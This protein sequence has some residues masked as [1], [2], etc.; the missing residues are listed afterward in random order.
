[1]LA[2]DGGWREAWAIDPD[3]D[4]LSSHGSSTFIRPIAGGSF[5]EYQLNSDGRFY[6]VN[7][8]TLSHSW[9]K[10]PAA[11]VDDL[12]SIE[13]ANLAFAMQAAASTVV[14]NA[15]KTPSVS[16]AVAQSQFQSPQKNASL[17]VGTPLK[18]SINETTTT[19]TTTTTT[20]VP[21][22]AVKSNKKST[23]TEAALPAAELESVPTKSDELDVF[24]EQKN[25][26]LTKNARNSFLGSVDAE[27]EYA[28]EGLDVFF[29][30]NGPW[31]IPTIRRALKYRERE[32]FG[33]GRGTLCG[34]RDVELAPLGPGVALYFRLLLFLAI[35]FAIL[36][37][38]ALPLLFIAGNGVR[39]TG[40]NADPFYVALLSIG[41]VGQLRYVDAVL[42][43]VDAAAEQSE[44]AAAVSCVKMW[45][46]AQNSLDS[47]A[48]ALLCPSNE[49]SINTVTALASRW[50]NYNAQVWPVPLNYVLWTSTFTINSSLGL[51]V[52]Y[53]WITAI[54]AGADVFACIV[55]LIGVIVFKHFAEKFVN[56]VENKKISASNYSVFVSGLPPGVSVAEIR[57]HFSH[58]FALDGTGYSA[59]NTFTVPSYVKFDHGDKS[60]NDDDDDDGGK[61]KKGGRGSGEEKGRKSKGGVASNEIASSSAVIAGGSVPSK[62]NPNLSYRNGAYYLIPSHT[63]V[64]VPRD[65]RLLG[66]LA[67]AARKSVLRRDKLGFITDVD[68]DVDFLHRVEVFNAGTVPAPLPNSKDL[69]PK[70]IFA[71]SWVA[72][73]EL[74][75]PMAALI[76]KYQAAQAFH[77]ELRT[78]RARVKMFSPGTPHPDGPDASARDLACRD[79]DKLSAKLAVNRKELE[80]ARVRMSRGASAASDC[81]GSAFVTFEHEESYQRCLRAY[82]TSISSLSWMQPPHLRFRS[83]DTP[84]FHSRGGAKSSSDSSNIPYS[85]ILN[86]H[87]LHLD[88]KSILKLGRI[89]NDAPGESGIAWSAYSDD[90]WTARGRGFALSVTAAPDPSD[91]IHENLEISRSS[92]AARSASTLLIT[93]AISALGFIFMFTASWITTVLAT[94][95][96]QLN[97]CDIQVPELYFGGASNLSLSQSRIA[98]LSTGIYGASTISPSGVLDTF[99]G[100]RRR[101]LLLNHKDDQQRRA[102]DVNAVYARIKPALTRLSSPALRSMEDSNCG[103]GAFV[104]IAYRFDFSRLPNESSGLSIGWSEPAVLGNHSNARLFGDAVA[105]GLPENACKP[106]SVAV[107]AASSGF[108]VVGTTS[109]AKLPATLPSFCPDPRVLSATNNTGVGGLCSC[110]DSTVTPH[111]FVGDTCPSLACFGEPYTSAA[112]TPCISFPA[113]TLI[114]CYCMSSLRAYQAAQGDVNGAVA[115]SNAEKDACS[116]FIFTLSVQTIVVV[117]V[118]CATT[119]VNVLLTIAVPWLTQFEGHRS[120]SGLERAAAW[121][122]ALAI[123]I[124]T[125]FVALLVNAKPPKGAEVWL[126]D[127]LS[128][129]GLLNG[130][131]DDFLPSWYAAVGTTIMTTM[132]ANTL[133]TPMFM[134]YEYIFDACARSAVKG[135]VGGV[136]TQMEMDELYVGA[137]FNVTTRYPVVLTMAFVTLFYST[138]IP[139]LF[140]LASLGFV[141]QYMVDKLMLLKFYRRPPAYDATMARLAIGALPIAVAVKFAFGFWMTTAPF[142]LPAPSLTPAALR[143]LGSV[144]S[145][146]EQPGSALASAL[147]VTQTFLAPYDT[148]GILPRALT[149]HGLVYVISALVIVLA[150]FANSIFTTIMRILWTIVYSITCGCA[151]YRRCSAHSKTTPVEIALAL[152][153]WRAH[154]PLGARLAAARVNASEGPTDGWLLGAHI[155]NLALPTLRQLAKRLSVVSR[156][157][158]SEA[159]FFRSLK[160]EP[161]AVAMAGLGKSRLDGESTCLGKGLAPFSREF[162]RIH[163]AGAEKVLSTLEV[164]LGWRLQEL[165]SATLEDLGSE[166]AALGFAAMRA[167]GG[168]GMHTAIKKQHQSYRGAAVLGLNPRRAEAQARLDAEAR[169]D[170]EEAELAEYNLSLAR[171]DAE[172]EAAAGRLL[173]EVAED[174]EQDAEEERLRVRNTKPSRRSFSATVAP[175]PL[176]P[177]GG[178]GGNNKQVESGDFIIGMDAV[179]ALSASSAAVGGN[180]SSSGNGKGDD[181]D[182]KA[183]ADFD[184]RRAQSLRQNAAFSEDAP[185]GA[186]ITTTAAVIAPIAAAVGEFPQ[187]QPRPARVLALPSTP[188]AR[189]SPR[190]HDLLILRQ[191]WLAPTDKRDVQAAMR[192][193]RARKTWEVIADS[194]LPTYEIQ[195]NPLYAAAFRAAAEAQDEAA[196]ILQ[197][198]DSKTN[199]DSSD[200]EEEEDD[201]SE[202]DEKK[203][204]LKK[205]K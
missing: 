16:V 104:S 39:S 94:T 187:Q 1:M 32:V 154:A 171:E 196:P 83:P 19:T 62:E 115:F 108:N 121:K 89:V 101:Q 72:A 114:G 65:Q 50:G 96:P 51:T 87:A 105:Y 92:R 59:A 194:G 170:Q 111:L 135:R 203:S 110:V 149:A 145:F 3:S 165:D 133:M 164:A 106:S 53:S 84:G 175:A 13:L 2:D 91:V 188:I 60:D 15:A 160:R 78:A 141:L 31:V 198:K 150:Y 132:I 61:D 76:T 74:V 71:H 126:P 20:V 177:Q 88:V 197:P 158:L 85:S 144:A 116:T 192:T 37:L 131:Y 40:A 129:V 146:L 173:A 64:R 178:G 124:N 191:L 139:L 63:T 28:Y 181:D 99:A 79:V 162:S 107:A 38:C 109:K 47:A 153:T 25:V 163:D 190:L 161:A 77:A 148:L 17:S 117:A 27:G 168:V 122:L 45:D 200:E 46:D 93:V 22:S 189:I 127:F 44:Y 95:A 11:Q 21:P 125:A 169:L 48:S 172:A 54:V 66:S 56:L 14:T 157:L 176:E 195:R 98:V 33:G 58:L 167:T 186:T 24:D 34:T 69:F 10:P 75:R 7:T 68:P 112:S 8:E 183:L 9:T 140:P 55:V 155:E 156:G 49:T 29:E 199:V 103:G 180:S 41:N 102:A 143:S 205:R 166:S 142:L 123:I 137:S 184:S 182:G 202:E 73:V 151:C 26:N 152:L 80:E 136:L 6:F 35:L 134:L 42:A 97:M 23:I 119:L 130:V 12:R 204:T 82:S 57:D 52:P 147:E 118:G 113:T 179:M 81:I 128:S 201:S 120:L 4:W 174:E 86:G 18:S 193:G 67:A 185:A 138:G 30:T 43:A 70:A 159:M 100:R 36:T 5:V 90:E